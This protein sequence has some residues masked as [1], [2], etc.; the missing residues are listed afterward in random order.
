MP[1]KIQRVPRGLNQILSIFGGASPT[2]MEDRVRLTLESLQ[3]YG[4][5]QLSASTSTNAA[6]A[7]G[8]NVSVTLPNAWTVLYSVHCS[9]V[10]TAT[11]TALR[12]SGAVNRGTLTGI[13]LFSEECG[14]FGAT[15]T[16]TIAVGGLLP[17][18]LVCPPLSVVSVTPLI[19]GTDATASVGC[20]TEFGLLG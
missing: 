4:T 14:P 7:E 13:L 9:V 18:P 12:M 6:T 8:A 15:E 11:M 17:Y 3:L 10:K 5:T 1:F 19:I 16:G 2:E 20:F